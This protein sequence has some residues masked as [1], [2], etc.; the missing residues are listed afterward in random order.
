M[1]AQNPF[2]EL[3]AATGYAFN[4]INRLSE[5][6]DEPDFLE[7]QLNDPAARFVVIGRDRPVLKEGNAKY[8]PLFT[9]NEAMALGDLRE[10]VFL[11]QSQGQSQDP[12]AIQPL[13]ALLLDDDAISI[14]ET[15]SADGLIDTRRQIIP[16][17]SDLAVRD[18][19][20]ITTEGHL[21]AEQIGYLGQAKSVMYWHA[22]HRFCSACGSPSNPAGAG[23]R[24]ECPN[25][26][27]QHFPRTDPVVIMLAVSGDD[28]LLGRSG[29]FGKG[30]YS[31][32]AGFLEPG[33]TMEDAVRREILEE[34][35]IRTGRVA[36]VASQPW[37][38]PSSLM[39]G[40][41]AE[42]LNRDIV[43][44]PKELEDCRWFSRRDVELMLAQTHPDGYQAPNPIA[45][46]HHLM[47]AWYDGK[48]IKF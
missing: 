22:R 15:V 48:T 26:G 44:D 43:I 28:C 19:R 46:A 3:S 41:V 21:P 39:M 1:P 5:R 35:G 27:A 10:T 16:G 47:R 13:F 8:D 18:L 31:A 30:M 9:R 7:S 6:R 11:G 14:V 33:E 29:R 20:A 37:P 2:H 42:A 36:Y 17:R 38:F 40:C 34:S 23:W 24:R 4:P 45:I 32:L 25:C 12:A